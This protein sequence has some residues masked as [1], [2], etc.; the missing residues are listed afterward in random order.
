MMHLD[1]EKIQRRE[2]HLIALIKQWII[3]LNIIVVQLKDSLSVNVSTSENN[4][5][6]RGH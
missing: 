3:G 4:K 6:I 1:T 2:H 5:Q